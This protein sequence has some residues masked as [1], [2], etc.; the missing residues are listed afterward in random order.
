[1]RIDGEKVGDRALQL[2]PGFDGVLQVGKRKF[3]KATVE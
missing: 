1:V 2:E 3:C